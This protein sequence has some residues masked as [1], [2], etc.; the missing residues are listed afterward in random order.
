[1]PECIYSGLHTSLMCLTFLRILSSSFAEERL[2]SG[3][4]RVQWPVC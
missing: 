3:H 2:Q 4:Y 1:M